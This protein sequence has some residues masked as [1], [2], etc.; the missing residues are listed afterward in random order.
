LTFLKWR[1]EEADAFES[2]LIYLLA[3]KGNVEASEA[4]SR[5]IYN[6][7]WYLKQLAID[8]HAEALQA[9]AILAI[10]ATEVV[11][12]HAV[13]H[14]E[15]F[16]SIAS[17][18]THWPFLKSRHKQLNLIKTEDEDSM[19]GRLKLGKNTQQDLAP[20]N[21]YQ[22]NTPTTEIAQK[23][24][25]YVRSLREY[26]KFIHRGKFLKAAQALDDLTRAGQLPEPA[27]DSK[28]AEAW[29]Q[30]AR[31]IL[32]ESYPRLDP[33]SDANLN[34]IAPTLLKVSQVADPKKRRNRILYNLERAFMTILAKPPDSIRVSS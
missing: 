32:L 25:D 3:K 15:V 29:W 30:L 7:F 27:Q 20:A 16:I 21:R 9:L 34:T 24:L 6:H 33:G 11:N 22:P 13:K 4:Y 14:P 18:Q 28:A 12:Q 5:K 10:E 8:G 26:S 31:L 23:L 17:R 2:E 19:L 1:F